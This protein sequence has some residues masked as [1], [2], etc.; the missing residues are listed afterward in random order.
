MLSGHHRKAA[1]LK[2]GL[3]EVPCWVRD[4]DDDAAYMALVTSNSQGEL[5]PLEIGLHA[6]HCVDLSGGGRGNKG[7]GLKEYAALVGR[8]AST[9]SEYRQAATV[10][11]LCKVF[12]QANTLSDKTKH[13]SAIHSLPESCW[14]AAVQIML[15]KAW[16]AKETGEQV[17]AANVGYSPKPTTPKPGPRW[18]FYYKYLRAL[19]RMPA[20]Y[21]GKP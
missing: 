5:S 13:L 10:Y 21:K 4:L 18:A 11:D 17:K 9:I 12:A 19:V 8:G 7:G 20:T 1:A 6:L 2:A 16:S 14:P 15:D 3:T